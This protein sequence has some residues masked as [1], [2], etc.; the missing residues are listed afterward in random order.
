MRGGLVPGAVAALS[1]AA[2]TAAAGAP[3]PKNLGCGAGKVV[4]ALRYHVV[5]DV[6]TTA[7]GTNWAFDDYTRVLRVVRKAAYRYCA[8]STYAGTFT[9]IAGP[10]P[11]GTATLP[12]GIRGT[13]RGSSVTTFR[14]SATLAGKRTRGDLG[15]KDFRCTSADTKGR[16]A[17]TWDWLRAYFTSTDNFASF[18]YKRYSFVYHATISGKGTY[19]DTLTGGKAR[20]H[21]DIRPTKSKRP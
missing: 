8:S 14:A 2:A 12:A 16:C 1:L 3:T 11:G 5:S 15:T 4:L 19:V 7:A 9:T 21:G 6:D 20:T 10:S 13:F 17:G 18:A